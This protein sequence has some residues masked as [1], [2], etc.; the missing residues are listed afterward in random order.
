MTADP[1]RKAAE[2]IYG[3]DYG[4]VSREDIVADY[5]AIIR[6]ELADV[7]EALDRGAAWLDV[8]SKTTDDRDIAKG[9]A[10]ERDCLRTALAQ[11]EGKTDAS[12]AKV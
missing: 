3:R 8:M 9:F 2:R 6:E 5:A 11:L 4:Q 10:I 7:V 12:P 1:I